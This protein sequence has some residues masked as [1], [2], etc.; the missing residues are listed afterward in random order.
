MTTAT[1]AADD[2]LNVLKRLKL[3]AR[4]MDNGW[5]IPFTNI[6][7]GADSVLGLVPGAGDIAAMLISLYVVVKAYELGAPNHILLRMVGNVAIDTGLGAVPLFGDIFDLF[8]KSNV[9]NLDLLH[10]FLRKTGKI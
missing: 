2:T 8:F 10:D 6:R 7:F 9:K 5:G 3:L 4:F 1:I